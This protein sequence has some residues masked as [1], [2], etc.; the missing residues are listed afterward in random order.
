MQQRDAAIKSGALGATTLV[1]ANNE[2]SIPPN[3]PISK[4]Y[5]SVKGVASI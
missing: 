2:L 1:Y 4:E 5:P 3:Y